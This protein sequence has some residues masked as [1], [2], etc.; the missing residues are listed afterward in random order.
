MN[1]LWRNLTS[2]FIP[3]PACRNAL[4]I[5][6]VLQFVTMRIYL[7]RTIKYCLKYFIYVYILLYLYL[8]ISLV[9]YFLKKLISF[10]N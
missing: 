8:S 1:A 5:V 2:H 9:V 10:R 3:K 6:E 4:L 7:Y